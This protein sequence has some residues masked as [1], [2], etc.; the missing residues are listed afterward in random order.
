[1]PESNEHKTRENPFFGFAKPYF[2][3][4]G[5]GKIYS[6]VY[7]MMAVIN[8][9]IPL[10]IIFMAIESDYLRNIGTKTMI[11]FML[12]WLVIAFAC[13]IGFQLWWYRKSIIKRY[14]N[15]DLIAIPVI[16]DLLQTIGEWM[17][18]IL[19]ITGIGVGL[20]LTTLLWDVSEIYIDYYRSIKIGPLMMVSGPVSGFIILVIF[21]LFAELIRISA[22]I[23]NNVREIAR[24]IK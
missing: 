24:K 11:A 13:W 19:C 9:L 23:A 4:I 8:L 22:S 7:V 6:L 16:S 10:V 18:T 1:M 5:R 14:V 20:I 15:Q 21:R 3:F 12:S 17:G 2:E